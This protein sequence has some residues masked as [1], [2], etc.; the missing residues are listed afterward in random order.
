MNHNNIIDDINKYY[1]EKII[2]HGATPQGVDWNGLDSQENRFS[3]LMKLVESE[4]TGRFSLLDFGCGY[5]S[6]LDYLKKLNKNTHYFGYDISEEM[7]KKAAENHSKKDVWLNKLDEHFKV[8]YVVASG[9]FNVKLNQNTQDW[10][11]Y[12]VETLD[13]FDKISNKGFAFNILTSY[14]DKHFMKEYLYYASPENYF[15]IC[16]TRYSK[17]ICLLHDY[18]LFEFT[19]LVKK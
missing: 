18:G 15:T 5:G 1:S 9:L 3:Q 16:K 17:Q 19:I 8:D 12:I 13:Y 14:S 10:E 7:L 4:S 6:L 2:A 11:N